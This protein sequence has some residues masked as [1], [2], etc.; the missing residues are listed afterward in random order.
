LTNSLD[1][2]THGCL[3]VAQQLVLKNVQVGSGGVRGVWSRHSLLTKTDRLLPLE[4]TV[5]DRRIELS[6][7]QIRLLER[8]SSEFRERHIATRHT[9][10]L[11]AVETFYVGAPKGIGRIYLQSAIDCHCRYAWGRLYTSKPPGTAIHLPNEDVLS[12]FE[13]H[14]VQLK[15]ILSDNGCESVGVPIATLTSCCFNE[16]FAQPP[17]VV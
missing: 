14:G 3:R 15:T 7:Q 9:G 10:E 11:V 6:D 8:F 13:S 17:G 5:R 16:T 12:F 2:P 4:N 1:Y